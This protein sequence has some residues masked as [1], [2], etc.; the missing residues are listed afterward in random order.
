MGKEGRRNGKQVM[1]SEDFVG[2]RELKGLVGV[3][4][5]ERMSWKD[6]RM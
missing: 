6:G 5:I 3:R 2:S 1:D 4:I